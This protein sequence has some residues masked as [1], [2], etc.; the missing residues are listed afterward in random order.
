MVGRLLAALPPIILEK[1][2]V[3]SKIW[4]MPKKNAAGVTHSTTL[5]L[6]IHSHVTDHSLTSS[7]R[8]SSGVNI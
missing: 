7:S 4:E 5:H 1:L 6:G 8:G 2:D 3:N